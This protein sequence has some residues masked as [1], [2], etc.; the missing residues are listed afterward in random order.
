MRIEGG[1]DRAR[2][3]GGGPGCRCGTPPWSASR[4]PP[5]ATARSGRG[6]T[7]GDGVSAR[8]PATCPIALGPRQRF[9]ISTVRRTLFQ[10]RLTQQELAEMIGTTRETHAHTL[11]DSRRRGLLASS[12]HSVV[13]RDAERV[14]PRPRCGVA[15]TRSRARRVV[16]YEQH[17]HA[18]HQRGPQHHHWR[19]RCGV[20]CRI[21]AGRVHQTH[22]L[23]DRSVNVSRRQHQMPHDPHEWHA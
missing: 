16:G 6:R 20:V 17:S 11:G 23:T 12:K 13:I 14:A 4:T 19:T 22:A 21:D 7:R 5:V 10:A 8:R 3:P 9:G 15:A 1:R 18:D 2:S